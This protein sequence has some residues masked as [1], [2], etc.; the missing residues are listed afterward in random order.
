[1]NCGAVRRVTYIA[2]RIVNTITRV[3]RFL[4]HDIKMLPRYG[5]TY[6][7]TDRL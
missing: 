1:V 4:D 7:R 3:R 6:C 2:S 5:V